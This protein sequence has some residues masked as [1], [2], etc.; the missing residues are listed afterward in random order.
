MHQADAFGFP[1]VHKLDYCLVRTF[2]LAL[3]RKVQTRDSSM[4]LAVTS[5]LL[6]WLC[7]HELNPVGLLVIACELP[8][9]QTILQK[10]FLFAV[11]LSLQR[12][13]K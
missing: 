4:Q 8:T 3:S 6:E 12:Q 13:L 5:L 2:D 7:K 1:F 9:F 11:L 10:Y